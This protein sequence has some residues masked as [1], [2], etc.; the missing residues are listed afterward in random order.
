[1]QQEDARLG[2][3]LLAAIILVDYAK[4]RPH[5]EQYVQRSFPLQPLQDAVAR[6]GRG[7]REAA[8]FFLSEGEPAVDLYLG[9]A[10]VLPEA[11]D[12]LLAAFA[13]CPAAEVSWSERCRGIA[14]QLQLLGTPRAQHALARVDHTA[15]EADVRQKQEDERDHAEFMGRLELAVP[16]FA[17]ALA[18]SSLGLWQLGSW[19]GGQRPSGARTPLATVNTA[20]TFGFV[21]GSAMYATPLLAASSNSHEGGFGLGAFA[22]GAGIVGAAVGLAGGAATG[23]WQRNNRG[24]YQTIAISELVVPLLLATAIYALD[25]R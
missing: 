13:R 8:R 22:L 21:L 2:A 14:R 25:S 5:I 12:V 11:E 10:V 16:T 23:Y 4:A 15:T 24:F 1:L 3:S 17:G 18:L 19:R 20:L 6:R 9:A 7:N